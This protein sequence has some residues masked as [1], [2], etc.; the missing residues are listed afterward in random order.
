MTASTLT[1]KHFQAELAALAARLRQQVER[2]VPGFSTQADEQSRRQQRALKEFQFFAKTYFPHYISRHDSLLHTYLYHRLPQ[3]VRARRPGVKLA[4]AAPRGEAKSTL[5]TQLFTLWCAITGRRRY[6]PIIMDSQHQAAAMLESIKAELESNRRLQL[7]FPD[8]CGAGAVWKAGVMVT[9]SGTKIQAFGSGRRMRGLR[10]GCHRPDMV[11]CD[12]LEND[13]NVRSRIQRDRLEEWLRTTVLKLGA[14]DDSMDVLVVGTL[15]H[16]DS[17][18]ARLLG[19]PLWESKRFQAIIQWPQ[20]MALWDQWQACLLREGEGAADAFFQHNRAAMEAGAQLSWP[21]VR[22]LESLMKIRARDGANAFD[23]E[24][25]NQPLRENAVFQNVTFWSTPNPHWV[26]FGAVDPSLGR[27]AGRGDPSAILLGGF[28]REKGILDV[29]EADIRPRLP[30]RIIADVIAYQARYG[31][32]LWV[33]EAVQFQ[34]FFKDELVRRSA[35]QGVPIPAR[36]IKPFRDKGLRISSL[37]PHIANGLI[38]F[39]PS[40]G[41]LLDQL[42]HWGE[43]SDSHD[44]GPDALEML[45]RAVHDSATGLGD[46]HSAGQRLAANLE[47]HDRASFAQQG[48]GEWGGRVDLAGY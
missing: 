48:F 1:P 4:I 47:Q 35:Q 19:N 3:V 28:D 29:V 45:W 44:D 2:H 8:D 18:L 6:I 14:A 9:N 46:V 22:S 32:R 30:D 12:D 40:Q 33:V 11:I 39:H 43:G 23:A 27:S 41:T 31:C 10:H 17:L 36:G 24:L 15:L 42:R 38:R 13:V 34:E 20:D 7:D 37:Q 26:L 21:K 5:V 25:Q 16:H